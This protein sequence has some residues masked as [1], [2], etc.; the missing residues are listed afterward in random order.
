MNKM[1]FKAGLTT[2]T[3]SGFLLLAACEPLHLKG[4]DAWVE[5]ET[6]GRDW[7]SKLEWGKYSSD[8][9]VDKVA[10]RKANEDAD[11]EDENQFIQ[12]FLAGASEGDCNKSLFEQ[13]AGAEIWAKIA[14]E[15]GL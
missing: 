15:N 4:H 10:N 14:R 11:V 12:G 7:V 13:K 2:L 1:I 8:Y 5:G 3:A 9:Y 6:Q